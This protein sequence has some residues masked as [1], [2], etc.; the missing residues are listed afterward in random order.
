MKRLASVS[1]D[2]D[3]IACYYR[4]HGLGPAPEELAATVYKRAV[5]RLLEE[6]PR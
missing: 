3:P 4:I 2:L 1:V 5:P 6:S